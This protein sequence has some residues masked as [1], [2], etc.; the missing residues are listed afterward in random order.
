MKM[1][2]YKKTKNGGDTDDNIQTSKVQPSSNQVSIPISAWKVLAILS[3]I[4]TMVMYAE[5]MLIP[6]IPDLIKDFAV[7][8]SMSSWILTAYLVSGAVMTPIAGKLSDI[9][10]RKKILLIIMVIYAVGVCLAGFSS[11]IF[12]M[13]IARAIQGIGMSMFPIAFGIVRDKFPREKISIGQ[14][15]ITSMFASGAVIGLAVGGY[16]IQNYGW[17]TTF[18]T[19]I[20]VA[21]VLLLIIRRFIF[22][23]DEDDLRYNEL[24]QKPVH[25][26][27]NHDNET[28][29]NNNNNNKTEDRA[30]KIKKN[31][32]ETGK[33]LSDQ[34]DL[35]GAVML[36]VAIASFLLVLTFIETSGNTDSTASVMPNNHNIYDNNIKNTPS[37]GAILPFLILAVTSFI[38][39]VVIEKR[40]KYPLVDFRLMLNK[41]ILPAN[42]I[43]M[44][45]GLSMF[46]VFQTIPILV[47]NPEP[48]GFGEDAISTGKVQLPFALILLVFGPTSGYIISK[49]GSLKPIIFGT[50]ITTAGFIGLLMFH[51][52]E[53]FVS[54][55]LAV[56]ST[57][58]SLTSV[59]AMNVIIL[60]TPRQFSG[61]SLGMSSLMR[62]IGAAIGPALAGMYMQTHQSLLNVNGIFGYFPSATSFN[63]IFISAVA[64]SFASVALAII[65]RRKVIKMAIPNLA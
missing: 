19:I 28:N 23:N 7:S 10:G 36:A 31:G 52:S 35:K 15:V 45:V 41:S 37:T 3:C 20:P 49:L 51:G 32:S 21:A 9:Y 62:I 33:R 26:K 42:L 47:R 17:R 38:L 46:M 39:F 44:L 50:F 16:I 58:L 12:F 25:I 29:N 11:N 65:L 6:A 40:A 27:R 60:S 64:F 55:N 18:F 59:G 56:L 24:A 53:L 34:I 2:R 61:I 43:I 22:V 1:L 4:A 8:Y 5:T 14:G 30:K 63:M 54:V 13:L 57:G 48:V